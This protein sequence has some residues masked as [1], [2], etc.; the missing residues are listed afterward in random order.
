MIS[1]AVFA[2]TV[3]AGA[4]VM[5]GS[6]PPA[7]TSQFDF[8]VGSWKC[9]GESYDASGK[10]THTDATNTIVK[11]FDGHVVQ[12]DFHQGGYH[13]MSMSVYDPNAKLWRQTWVD[14]G[15][16]YIAL[17]G[18]FEK[19][20]MTLQTLPRPNKPDSASRMVFSNIQKNSF[21]WNWEST[22]DGGKSWKL[23]W[24]LHYERQG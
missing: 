1:Y 11:S 19:G 7:E 17:T 22:T 12:E 9:S 5:Q 15:G 3:L 21:D 18:S 14:N 2:A 6:K 10:A 24:R 8:W 4:A 23:Q 20:K 16:A 13:G